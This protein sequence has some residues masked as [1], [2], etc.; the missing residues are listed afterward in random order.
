MAVAELEILSAS[1]FLGPFRHRCWFDVETDH[2]SHARPKNSNLQSLR[3]ELRA[4]T[5]CGAGFEILG[6]SYAFC[7]KARA[8]HEKPDHGPT[9][10]TALLSS[11]VK[12]EHCLS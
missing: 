2:G 9:E 6:D 12:L 3:A 8:V 4:W 7:P 1:A 10:L 11:G 5:R